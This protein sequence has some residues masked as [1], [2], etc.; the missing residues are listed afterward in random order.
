MCRGESNEK[1][2]VIAQPIEVT[3]CLWTKYNPDVGFSVRNSVMCSILAKVLS[4][5]CL[6]RSLS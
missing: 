6:G 4:E 1:E 2:M 3:R 5:R